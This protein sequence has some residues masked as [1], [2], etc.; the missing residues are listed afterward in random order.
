MCL[1]HKKSWYGDSGLDLHILMEK[2]K[3]LSQS[4]RKHG[5]I[6]TVRTMTGMFSEW[7]LKF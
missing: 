1:E 3:S 4:I 7:L 5:L 2:A 6:S